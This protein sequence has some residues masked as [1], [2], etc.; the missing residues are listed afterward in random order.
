MRVAFHE[1]QN[2]QCSCDA[3]RNKQPLLPTA[4]I[5]KKANSS[6]F[7][8]EQRDIEYLQ[9]IDTLSESQ[10]ILHV[11]LGQLIEQDQ[12]ARERKPNDQALAPSL[13]LSTHRLQMV[14]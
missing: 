12:H 11:C 2:D 1:P 5:C 9:D 10:Q 14:G 8:V 3:D 6:A 13:R 7:V 4:K